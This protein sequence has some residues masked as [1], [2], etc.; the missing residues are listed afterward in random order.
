MVTLF[1]ED[2]LSAEAKDFV[3]VSEVIVNSKGL[4]VEDICYKD[5]VYKTGYVDLL[6]E[7]AGEAK[8]NRL[9]SEVEVDRFDFTERYEKMEKLSLPAQLLIDDYKM[10]ARRQ[11]QVAAKHL[12]LAAACVAASR[13]IYESE[14]ITQCQTSLQSELDASYTIENCC[15]GV[16][17]DFM[18]RVYTGYSVLMR[19]HVVSYRK[20]PNALLPDA[21]A[22][23]EYGLLHS[24]HRERL[25]TVLQ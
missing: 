1:E 9:K 5:P 16:L 23:G 24:R 13:S 12:E 2:L 3:K 20:W 7:L 22:K 15:E 8:D 4:V 25:L 21:Q 14:A 18:E 6:E 11:V 17:R 10:V 19:T